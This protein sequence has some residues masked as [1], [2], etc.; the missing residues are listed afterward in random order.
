MRLTVSI[1]RAEYKEGSS[2]AVKWR[3]RA[4]EGGTEDWAICFQLCF[5]LLLLLL[6]KEERNTARTQP[7]SYDYL[8]VNSFERYVVN[9]IC[10]LVS[11]NFLSFN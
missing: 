5:Q 9:Y 7:F 3:G 11:F 10:L 2:P 4:G 1:Q 8:F 6:L